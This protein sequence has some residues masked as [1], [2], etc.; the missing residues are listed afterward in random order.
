M[1]FS[2]PFKP[3][4]FYSY[5]SPLLDAL[6]NSQHKKVKLSPDERRMLIAWMDLNSPYR[7]VDQLHQMEDP[8]F[9]GSDTVKPRPAF[10]SAPII[11]RP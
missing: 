5:N 1:R 2:L 8:V 11:M 3:M 9:N 6:K 7:G 4:T 10:K